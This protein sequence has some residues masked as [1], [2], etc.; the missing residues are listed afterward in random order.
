MGLYNNLD[1][2]HVY[3]LNVKM[4]G[5][6]KNHIKLLQSEK[7]YKM[8]QTYLKNKNVRSSYIISNNLV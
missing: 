7:T 6:K 5:L 8:V 1:S 4:S 2:R 3:F